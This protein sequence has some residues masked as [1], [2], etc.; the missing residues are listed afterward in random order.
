[1]GYI[2]FLQECHYKRQP[3]NCTSLD[4]LKSQTFFFDF[5]KKNSP[6]LQNVDTEKKAKKK[7]L[8]YIEG[9]YRLTHYLEFRV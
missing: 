9:V 3:R 1:M 2:A 6:K 5:L 7:P 4:S 8:Y